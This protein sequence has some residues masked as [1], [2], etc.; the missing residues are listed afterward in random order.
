M[1]EAGLMMG[2]R[3]GR[4]SFR[5]ELGMDLVSALLILASLSLELSERSEE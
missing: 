4:V 3:D 5:L 1:V 2:Q